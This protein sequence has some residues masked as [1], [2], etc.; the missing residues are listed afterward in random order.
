[1]TWI[2]FRKSSPERRDNRNYE[3]SFVDTCSPSML[4]VSFGLSG[5]R[6]YMDVLFAHAPLE[7]LSGFSDVVNSALLH[8]PIPLSAMTAASS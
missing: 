1:M 6:F 3:K 7:A 5:S 2:V 8:C 4:D